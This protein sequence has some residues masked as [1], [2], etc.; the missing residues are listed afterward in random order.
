MR[1]D[2]LALGLVE[3]GIRTERSDIRAHVSVVNRAVYVFKTQDGLSAIT[4]SAREERWASQPGV[5]GPTA[6]GW[7][8][9]V[10]A[11]RDIR[12]LR[13]QSWEGWG[14]FQPTLS[15]SLKGQ[16]AV[17]CVI[18]TM[19]LGRFPL[20]FDAL[21]DKDERIQQQGT[22]ILVFCRKK[23]QVKCDYYGGTKP[24][25]TGNLFFQSH[26]RNPLKRI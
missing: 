3:Y 18:A 10:E 20:W 24:L 2:P 5:S 19:R 7:L 1:Q 9:P 23:I 13:F 12:T 15:T 22:D 11:I 6:K 8:V 25:G 17:D 4:E 26:E 16:L 14:D 21:E